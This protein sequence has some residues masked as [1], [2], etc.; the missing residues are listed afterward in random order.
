LAAQRLHPPLALD[1]LAGQVVAALRD[2]DA[3]KRAVELAVSA[4]VQAMAVAA[5]DEAGIGA[6]P[7]MRARELGVG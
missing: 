7:A 2:G 4:T 3:V 6:T 5:P 1:L